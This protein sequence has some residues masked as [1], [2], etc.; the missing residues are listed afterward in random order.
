MSGEK[1]RLP[2]LSKTL[3]GIGLAL[4]LAVVLPVGTVLALI[5][6]KSLQQDN[7]SRDN[8]L[9]PIHNSATGASIPLTVISPFTNPAIPI[10]EPSY[11]PGDEIIEKRTRTTKTTYLGETPDGKQEYALDASIGSVHY[12]DSQGNWQNINNQIVNGVMDEAGYTFR[13]L[14][15]TFNAGQVVEFAKGGEYVRLQPMALEWTNN[16]SQIQQISMP[17]TV[18]GTVT[19]VPVQL[20]PGIDSQQGKITWLNAYGAGRDFTWATQPTRLTKILTIP[21][22]TNLPSPPSYIISGGNPVLRLNMIFAPSSGVEI[23]VDGKLWNKSTTVQTFERIEFKKNG[24]TLWDFA[25]LLYWDS[26]DNQGESIKTLRK[27]GNSLYIEIQVP[28]SWLQTATYPVYID[29]TIDVQVE[30][31]YD[32]ARE[33]PDQPYFSNAVVD[34]EVE[35]SGTAS[36]VT[37]SGTRFTVTIPVGADITTANASI[38]VYGSNDDMHGD[39]YGHDVETSQDFNDDQTIFARTRTSANVTWDEEEL[40]NLAWNDSPDLEPIIQELNDTY[41]HSAGRALTLLWIAHGSLV[42]TC[43]WSSHD[44]GDGSLATKLHIEYSTGGVVVPT[45][46]TNTANNVEETTAQM[47]GNITATGGENADYEGFEWGTATGNYTDNYTYTGNYG[48]GEFLYT[49][50]AFSPGTLYF[51][52][53]YAHN[54]AGWGYGDEITFITK[55]EAPTSLTDPARLSS[56]ITLTWTKGT[57]SENTTIRY[58]DDGSYPTDYADGTLGYSGTAST[59]NVTGLSPSIQYHIGAWAV[60]TDNTTVYSDSS[61]QVIAWTRPGDATSANTSNPDYTTLDLDW[62]KGASSNRTHW[63]WDIG[64]YPANVAAGTQA[65]FGTDNSTTVISLPAGTLIYFNGWAY[66][67]NSTYY[68]SGNVSTTGTTIAITAPT[69][70]TANAT[71]ILSTSV[72]MNGSI[73]ATNGQDASSRGFEWGLISANYTDNQTS[74]GSFGVGVFTEAVAGLSANTTYYYRAMAYNDGGWGYG[75][76]I[77]FVTLE[78]PGVTVETT[79][80]PD[81][82]GTSVTL[83]GNITD[84]G[85]G[86]CDDRGF[87][88]GTTSHANPGDIASDTTAYDSYW[89]E[90][91]SF[92]AGAFS[93][94]VTGLTAL[95][96]Y[97]YRAFTSND[98]TWVYGEEYSFFAVVD[99]K[100]YL[101]FRPDLDETGIVKN[102]FTPTNAYVGIYHGY[103]LPIWNSDNETLYFLMCVPERWDGESDIIFHIGSALANANESGNGYV[104]EVAWEKATPNAEV[105]PVTNYTEY[106]SR[107]VYSN[108]QYEFYQDW[109]SFNYDIEPDDPI[110]ADDLLALRIRR[111]NTLKVDNLDG[112]L[113]ITH[114]GI[115]F[116]RGDL[117]GDPITSEANVIT[118]VGDLIED[119][120]LIGGVSVLLLAFIILA[121]GLMITAYVFRKMFIAFGAGAAWLLLGLYSLGSL[122][123]STWDVYY[124]VFFFSLGL[125]IASIVEAMALREKPESVVEKDDLDSYLD[126]REESDRKEARFR[127]AIRPKTRRRRLSKFERTGKL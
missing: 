82:D 60:N 76:E 16:L 109:T 45:V 26:A 23:Y 117:L 11:Q 33:R 86:T 39:I 44:S 14:Q 51:Y 49:Y 106:I 59:C 48:V 13:L 115:L 116:A 18:T 58:R 20:L 110:E 37:H 92:N 122:S 118:I 83:A 124:G 30:A 71:D 63:R 15:S 80:N 25:P 4:L 5:P 3:I 17:Q 6:N 66:S 22:L 1:I 108:N 56:Q 114:L 89:N 8:F 121:L 73:T 41:D 52:R 111:V 9:M 81:V 67:D 84:T 123:E 93:H 77:S 113:I 97:Y 28:Y 31:N 64:D 38:Y 127:K 120:I 98:G 65:Y 46:V 72:T 2:R 29:T 40:D 32:D 69:V 91:G 125:M 68:S 19:N 119:G 75:G 126:E 107:T 88:Y 90:E 70:T 12:K 35:W 7:P 85:G 74:A 34:C 24:Q 55:P 57:G 94:E 102:N 78:A 104:L 21:G 101:E 62:T 95:T 87:V 61:A 99:G 54:S 10:A 112:E 47:S 27:A 100:I 42:K 103:S 36:A 79:P 50:E 53:A 43:G 105:L 96:V